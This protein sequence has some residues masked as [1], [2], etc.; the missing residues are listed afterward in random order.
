MGVHYVNALCFQILKTATAN[1]KK[2][3]PLPQYYKIAINIF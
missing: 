3:E 1:D 2:F